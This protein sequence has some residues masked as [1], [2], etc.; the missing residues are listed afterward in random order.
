MQQG[1]GTWFV[2]VG[3]C[4]S[5]TTLAATAFVCSPKLWII[6]H[7]DF[8]DFNLRVSLK[9]FVQEIWRYLLTLARLDI[10]RRQKTQQMF[11]TSLPASTLSDDIGNRAHFTKQTTVFSLTLWLLRS[12]ICGWC[13]CAYLECKWQPSR[14]QRPLNNCTKVCNCSVIHA[15][16]FHAYNSGIWR[17]GFAL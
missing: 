12:L 16:L 6:I 3:G 15:Y 9:G 11:L 1:Y 2:C 13:T 5:V 7:Q 10:F 8:L 4:L 17:R 14:V